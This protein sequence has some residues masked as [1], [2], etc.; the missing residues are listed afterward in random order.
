MERGCDC[1]VL[2]EMMQV[3]VQMLDD[4]GHSL[5]DMAKMEGPVVNEC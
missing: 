1:D 2:T 5:D 3:A 4:C